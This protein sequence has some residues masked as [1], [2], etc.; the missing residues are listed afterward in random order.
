MLAGSREMGMVEQGEPWEE[1]RCAHWLCEPSR[2][3]LGI[4]R[5]RRKKEMD[6]KVGGC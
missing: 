5:R 6:M 3:D 2:L 4:H 1:G